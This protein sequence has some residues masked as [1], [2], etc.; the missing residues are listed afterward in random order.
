MAD[1]AHPE[2]DLTAQCD[3]GAIALTAR[4]RVVSMFLCAC[5]NCQKATGSGHSTVVLVPAEVI[6]VV[7]ATKSFSRPAE[8]GATF[9]RHFCPECGTT[10]YAQSS[11]APAVRILTA[12][13]FAGQNDW[14]APNQL[15]FSR[16]HQAWDLVADHLPRYATYRLEPQ[17]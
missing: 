6:R 4:G 11:R 16:S 9:T 1:T 15:I 3:C 5:K 17:Q 12:G 14:F 2:I 7:G 8:S 10:L 13:L